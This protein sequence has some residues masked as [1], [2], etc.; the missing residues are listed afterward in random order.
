MQGTPKM[1][2]AAR[3]AAIERL[4]RVIEQNS[5][6]AEPI[7][8]LILDDPAQ[9]YLAEIAGGT[10]TCPKAEAFRRKSEPRKA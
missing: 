6:D 2:P 10:R 3:R 5:G 9:Q 7:I 4:A 1:K 8:N